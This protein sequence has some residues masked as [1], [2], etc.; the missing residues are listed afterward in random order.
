MAEYINVFKHYTDFKGRARRS[1]FWT[2]N[3]MHF[4]FCLLFIALTIL[5]RPFIILYSLYSLG[6]IVPGIAVAIRRLHDINREGLW[7]L[8]QF[9]PLVGGIW[10]LILMIKEGTIGTNTYGVDPKEVSAFY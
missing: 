6:A 5:Y 2:F 9:V 7:F 8:I 3:L 10:F 1:E 4:V